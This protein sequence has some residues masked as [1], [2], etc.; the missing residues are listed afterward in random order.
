MSSK[1]NRLLIGKIIYTI[2]IILIYLLC[3]NIPLYKINIDFYFGKQSDGSNLLLQTLGGDANQCTLFALGISPYMIASIFIQVIMSF[4][5]AEYKQRT[6]PIKINKLN[7]IRPSPLRRNILQKQ[8]YK[9]SW[10]Y[11][12]YYPFQNL[13][14]QYHLFNWLTQ[15]RGYNIMKKIAKTIFFS[16]L[17]SVI[18][19]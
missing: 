12:I 11:K 5:S 3:K 18:T 16:Y 19:H 9:K 14:P 15:R 1:K 13:S 4:R 2:M 10:I 17:C 7:R 6:S 8:R